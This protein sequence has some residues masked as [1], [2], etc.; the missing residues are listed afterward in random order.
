[1]KIRDLVQGSPEWLEFRKSHIGGSDISAITGNNPWKNNLFLWEEKTGKR[2]NNYKNKAMEHGTNTEG[3]A[4]ELY[5]FMNDIEM[6]P[7]VCQSDTWEVAISSLDGLSSDHKSILEVKCPTSLKLYEMAL[8]DEIPPYYVDQMQWSLFVTDCEY[9]DFAV[10]V[11]HN[12]MKVIK[13]F[14]DK[15]YQQNLLNEA[16]EFWEYVIS[17][18]EPPVKDP[19]NFIDDEKDNKLA[20]ELINLDSIEKNVTEKIE[21]IKAF[22]KEKYKDQKKYS[23]VNAKVKMTWREG[24]KTVDWKSY[25]KANNIKDDDL[26]DYTKKSDNACAFTF[27]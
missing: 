6:T 8:N 20:K 21:R 1:M 17:K 24:S 15:E 9:C 4:R 3:Q 22:F 19:I 14:P 23:F 5:C 16:K 2:K 12:N 27:V 7:E 26:K 10:Y 18:T 25:K 11:N 13:V